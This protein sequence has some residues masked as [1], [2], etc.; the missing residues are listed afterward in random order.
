MRYLFAGIRGVNG[1]RVAVFAC[2]G[3]EFVIDW[4]NLLDRIANMER[5]GRDVCEERIALVALKR[6]AQNA[7]VS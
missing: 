6:E 2:C 4:A 3:N 1:K 7:Q 5:D